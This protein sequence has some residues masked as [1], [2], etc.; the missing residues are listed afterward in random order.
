M[1]WHAFVSR[2]FSAWKV[3][4]VVLDYVRLCV[5]V[6]FECSLDIVFLMLM[7]FFI[8]EPKAI[9]YGEVDTSSSKRRFSKGFYL[10]PIEFDGLIGLIISVF[11]VLIFATRFALVLL[12]ACPV[13]SRLLFKSIF[14]FVV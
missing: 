9:F 6:R 14:V 8:F 10:F 13:R 2:T 11:L 5:F 1:L 7:S 4:D 12:V 3:G